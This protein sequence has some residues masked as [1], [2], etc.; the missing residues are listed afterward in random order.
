MFYLG[1][2]TNAVCQISWLLQ[3][4]FVQIQMADCLQQGTIGTFQ[5]VERKKNL[6]IEQ[7]ESYEHF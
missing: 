7:F 3:L 4:V 5:G 6:N 2:S 1:W